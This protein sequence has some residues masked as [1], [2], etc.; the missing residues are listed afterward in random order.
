[1][2]AL[3]PGTLCVI[4]DGCPKNIGLIVEV[5]EHI[6]PYPPRSDAYS[7]RTVTG[8]NFPQLKI[9]EDE[10]L[11]PGSF[12]EAITDRH[13]LRP[14]VGPKDDPEETDAVEKPVQ[15]R[16]RRIATSLS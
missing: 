9:G 7:I 11:E 1:M 14:L 4:I 15:Q 16:K 3:K 12:T 5:L 8:R 2:S 6:G 10:R 13:K